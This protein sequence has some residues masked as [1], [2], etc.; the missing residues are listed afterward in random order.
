[1]KISFLLPVRRLR[2]IVLLVALFMVALTLP[3]WAVQWTQIAQTARHNVALDSESVRITSLGRLGVWIRFIPRGEIH[4]REAAAEHNQKEYRLHLEYY[5]IDCGDNSSVMGLTD[6]LGADGRRLSRK[7][8]NGK[9]E[10]I[11]TGSALDLAALKVCPQLGEIPQESNEAPPP[12]DKPAQQTVQPPGEL[13]QQITDT[14]QQT[15]AAP[16]D[17]DAWVKLGNAYYDADMPEKAIPAYSQALALRPRDTDVLNDQGAMYR[18]TGDFTKAVANFEKAHSI[19]PRNLESLY[20]TGYVYAFDL[21]RIDKALEIWRRYLELD[22][23]SETAYQ[24]RSFIE[25]YGQ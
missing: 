7:T 24:V 15:K 5:E 6:V 2:H 8:G 12:Y 13:Q 25:R 10:K 18:Q 19:D 22:N 11:V 4:R 1:M 3:T 20:N 21:N 14:L 17:F 9:P 16:N 23:S